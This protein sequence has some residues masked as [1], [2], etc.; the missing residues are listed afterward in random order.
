MIIKQVNAREGY[1]WLRQGFWLFKQ[2]P[3]TFLML[4]FLYIFLVQL[5]MF[6][7]V[8][9]IIIMMGLTPAISVGMM[10]A[11][12]KIIRKERVTPGVFLTAFKDFGAEVRGNIL[13][14]GLI[15]TSLIFLLSFIATQFVDFEKLIPLVIEQK[16]SSK[17]IVKELYFAIVIGALLYIP[18]AMLTWFSPL[19]ICWKGM[20]TVKAIF[21]SWMACWMNRGAFFVFISMWAAIL[22]AAPLFLEAIMNTLGLENFASFV[23]TPFQMGAITVMYC[24]FFAT[25]KG[26][27]S[28]S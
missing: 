13:K 21:G 23:I 12:Q 3:F 22:I 2:N 24:S 19:L 28:D 25:W 20:P 18:I 15:Y 17:V 4:V 7:P 8:L 10:T 1:V 9:G 26:C 6:I 11:C 27:F 14:L 16:I 5:S